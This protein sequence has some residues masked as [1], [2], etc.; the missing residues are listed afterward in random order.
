M[1]ILKADKTE[2]ELVSCMKCGALLQKERASFIVNNL[3][4]SEYYCWTDKPPYSRIEYPH[5]YA[6]SP[7]R[8]FKEVQCDK[9][10]ETLETRD[11][12]KAKNI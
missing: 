7:I 8:Y 4:G 5:P 12:R 6:D 10:G 3:S 9:G 2:I 11:I 1:K